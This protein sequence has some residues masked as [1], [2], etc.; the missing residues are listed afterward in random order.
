M[1]LGHSREEAEN[2]ERCNLGYWGGYYD[3]E[4]RLRVERLFRCEHP[5]F[6][7]AADGQPAPEEAFE[8]GRQLAEA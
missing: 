7:L 6:G 8:M 4:T 2:I 5:F 3:L 1:R